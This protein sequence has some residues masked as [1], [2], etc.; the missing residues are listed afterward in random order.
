MSLLPVGLMGLLSKY[1]WDPS[2]IWEQAL[3]FHKDLGFFF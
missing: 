3:K 1:Q 2:R